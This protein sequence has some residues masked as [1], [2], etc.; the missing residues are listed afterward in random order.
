MSQDF[1]ALQIA[2]YI[3]NQTFLSPSFSV[4]HSKRSVSLV[5]LV[6][7]IQDHNCGFPSD[8][9]SDDETAG[10]M[11]CVNDQSDYSESKDI[12]QLGE[13]SLRDKLP[14][15]S[16]EMFRQAAMWYMDQKMIY[17]DEESKVCA[18]STE[19][20]ISEEENNDTKVIR[21]F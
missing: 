7:F 5:R 15:Y 11:N 16:L 1:H 2:A 14:K 13:S 10:E 19:N 21:S 18:S 17:N 6:R 3:Q 9:T 20:C 4:P 12:P 8:Y